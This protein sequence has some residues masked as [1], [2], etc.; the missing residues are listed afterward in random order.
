MYRLIIRGFNF[1]YRK[2]AVVFEFFLLS[3]P[4]FRFIKDTQSLQFRITFKLWF[5]QKILGFNRETYW[6]V[7]FTSKINQ[8]KN[9]LVGVE[10]NPGC[11]PGCY[12]QGIGKVTIGD[13]TRIAQNVG[14]ISSNHDLY[15]NSQHISNSTVVIGSYCWIG[16][17]SVILPNVKLGD[18]TIVG[19]GS[20]VTKS[21]ED[22]FCVIGGNPARIIKSLEKSSCIRY[23]SD[24]EYIGYLRKDV[25]QQYRQSNLWV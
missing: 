8:F 17:N 18:F 6:P 15:D 9:I 25:F 7:H 20:V 12:I 16:M 2:S 22:G 11:E 5:F 23:K 10:S 21:F 14:I 1:V 3:I 4:Y 13:Y 24:N 19:A